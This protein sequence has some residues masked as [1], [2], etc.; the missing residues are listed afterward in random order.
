MMKQLLLVVV[1]VNVNSSRSP[2]T[3]GTLTIQ[4][5]PTV[6]NRAV[7]IARTVTTLSQTH[8]RKLFDKH[9][10]VL[11]DDITASRFPASLVENGKFKKAFGS[12]VCFKLVPSLT[13]LLTMTD[14]KVSS[15]P[16]APTVREVISLGFFVGAI[17]QSSEAFTSDK[18]FRWK[19]TSP[20]IPPIVRR[21]D[22]PS[23][24]FRHNSTTTAVFARP[25]SAVIVEECR[26]L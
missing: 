14:D 26:N 8:P 12:W 20:S 16:W 5:P 24:R 11:V 22:V 18:S 15:C 17:P 4:H 9:N 10:H 6:A 13:S 21:S 23:R 7:T 1:V 3:T 2:I 25:S 19:R